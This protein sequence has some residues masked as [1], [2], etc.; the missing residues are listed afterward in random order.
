MTVVL[1]GA[2]AGLGL[3]AAGAHLVTHLLYGSASADW[4][5]YAAAALLV[6]LVGFVASWMP[7]RRAASSNRWWRF[8]ANEVN[9]QQLTV[10]S[11][12]QR[13]TVDC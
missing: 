4:L 8:G 6:S 9:S 13:L 10:D 11:D 3:A 1:F 7:A 12:C 5:F 2:I